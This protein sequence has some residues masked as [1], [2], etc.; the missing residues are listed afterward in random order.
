MKPLPRIACALTLG[1]GL[2]G[3]GPDLP[4]RDKPPEPQATSLSDAIR[5]PLDQAAAVQ[6]TLDE[7]ARQQKAAVDAAA[8]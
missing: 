2:S 8:H 1:L 3:C 6:G 7:A 5:D 4:P